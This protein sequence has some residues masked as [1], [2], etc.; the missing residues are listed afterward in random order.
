MEGAHRSEGLAANTGEHVVPRAQYDAFL[1]KRK[2][3][4]GAYDLG[5]EE[6]TGVCQKCHRL[7]TK[8]IGPA[9][10]NNSLLAQRKGLEVLLRNGQGQM[11]A[12]GKNWTGAQIDAL[13]GY[14]KQ[15]VAKGGS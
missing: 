8:Y 4:A 3:A 7:D 10:K 12:V 9:L 6:W 2:G 11:P 14:T 1:S 15:F 13:I 5:R